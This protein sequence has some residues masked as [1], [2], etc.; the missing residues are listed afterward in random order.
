MI[1]FD[2]TATT[3]IDKEVMEIYIKTQNNFFA[4]INSLHKLGQKSNFMFEKATE[5]LKQELGLKH[6]I[7][8]TSNATEANNLGI[9]GVVERYEK[10]KIITTKIEHPSVFE[11]FKNLEARG[12]EVV[13]LD[14]DENGIINLTQLE[15]ELNKDVLLVSVMW[16]N[17]I[18]GSIQPIDK[19]IKLV[20][21]YPKV[22]LHV[23]VVQGIC[24]I[25][26]NFDFNDI[27]LLSLSGHK[28]YAPKGIGLLAVRENVELT[29]RLYGASNQ[30]KIKPGTLDLA[31]VV[32]LCKAVKIFTPQVEE[33]FIYVQALNKQLRE[34]V[35]KFKNIIINSPENASPYIFNI[36]IPNIQ[37]ETLLHYLEE[38]E[39]FVSTG[40]ACSSKLKKPEKT[41]YAMTNSL[42]RATTSV[43]I[44]LSHL[45]TS[46]EVEKLIKA[47]EKLENV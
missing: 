12:Y 44:S 42:E 9:F 46:Q 2:Y 45:T 18:V 13:Y 39:I 10:G 35:S 40:S 31:L 33:H 29:S 1:Y 26:P 19:V 11:V 4:N 7:I 28:I 17:N 43:R 6:N 41:I 8:Y 30:Y 47:L 38:D 5:E 24:K 25:V 37:G 27:D 16:V 22:K 32:A 34:K 14:V 36:S 23:D 20:K 15:E 21:K 3:P